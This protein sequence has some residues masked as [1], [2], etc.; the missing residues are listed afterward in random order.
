MKI[1]LVRIF[2]ILLLVTSVKSN[3][4]ASSNSLSSNHRVAAIVNDNIISELE[5]TERIN[6]IIATTGM[7][8]T[9]ETNKML[10]SQVMRSLIDESLQISEVEKLNIFISDDEITQAINTL[11]QQRG[12]DS[13]SLIAYM[14]ANNVDVQTFKQQLKAQISWNKLIG[15]SIA[16]KISISE[17]EL[18][19]EI[20]F[21]K[22]ETQKIVQVLLSGLLLP[23]SSPSEVSK[24]EKLASHL[25]TEMK[26]G[27]SYDALASQLSASGARTDKPTWVDANK[28]DPMIK[29]AIA[30]MDKTAISS[31][32]K[33]PA[34]IQ[35]VK[36]HNK[37]TIRIERDAEVLLKQLILTL[38]NDAEMKDVDVL[39]D[40]AKAVAKKPGKCKDKN[41]AGINDFEGLNIDISNVRTQLSLMSKEVLPLIKDLQVGQVAEP[42]AA[43]DG[44]HLLQLCEKISLPMPKPDENEMKQALF[45]KKLELESLKYLRNLR[46]DA[47]IDI[48]L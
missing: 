9:P 5:V 41:I 35:I 28:L 31:P 43:P 44:I 48:R 22:R 37:R 3:A 20:N 24:V 13:G 33:M 30:K 23:V 39:M 25:V 16:P 1:T 4:F 29:D 6:L 36:L 45:N 21:R 42:F 14:K 2:I 8:N 17:T 19:N 27:A 32:I 7:Q 40:I 46:R 11:E 47:F 18:E 10:T 38:E 26:N 34:G 12:K 15:R